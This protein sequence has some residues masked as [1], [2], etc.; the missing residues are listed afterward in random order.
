MDPTMLSGIMSG[1]AQL[2]STAMSN[3]SV[4]RQNRKSRTFARGMYEKQR[5]DNIEFWRMQNSYNDPAQQME[6]LK[7]AGLNPAL[8][9]GQ[10][11]G[12]ASG[13]AG[14]IASPRV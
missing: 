6:R 13:S 11:A 9:Y 7:N 3:A 12:G 1:G 4:A 8:I 5:D 14:S 2:I 10:N